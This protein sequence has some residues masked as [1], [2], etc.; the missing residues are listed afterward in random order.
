M[1]KQIASLFVLL[2]DGIFKLSSLRN[3]SNGP[4]F[5]APSIVKPSTIAKAGAFGFTS[6]LMEQEE[7]YLS[8]FDLKAKDQVEEE[9]EK[10]FNKYM[11]DRTFKQLVDNTYAAN[12]FEKAWEGFYEEYSMLVQF[13]GGLATIFPGTSTVESDFSIIGW[14]KDEYRTQLSNLS[15][16]GILHA[17]QFDEMHRIRQHT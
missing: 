11:H 10:F 7:R 2:V 13:S 1:L 14:E 16:E 4:V 6:L 5:R 15:L 12:T 9:S 3:S 17:K 8:T